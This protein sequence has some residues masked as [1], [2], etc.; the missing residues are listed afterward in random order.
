MPGTVG[1][2]VLQAASVLPA[3]SSAPATNAAWAQALCSCVCTTA[4][5]STPVIPIFLASRAGSWLMASDAAPKT[6]KTTYTNSTMNRKIRKASAPA[7]MPPPTRAS[8]S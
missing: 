2:E 3:G 6:V 8:S 4:L 5:A 1:D 7:R